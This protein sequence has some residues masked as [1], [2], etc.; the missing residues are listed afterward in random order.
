MLS[1][2]FANSP[3]VGSHDSNP[4]DAELQARIWQLEQRLLA[5]KKQQPN[6]EPKPKKIRFG[7]IRKFFKDVIVPV[8][9]FI[10]R[11]ISAITDFKKL[12]KT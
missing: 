11:L 9:V 12:A 6:P 3:T 10:P 2:H 8:L 1:N 4:A 5:A 7:K